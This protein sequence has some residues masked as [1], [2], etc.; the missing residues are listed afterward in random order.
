MLDRI[1]FYLKSITCPDLYL[2]RCSIGLY[3]THVFI[4]TICVFLGYLVKTCYKQQGLG[5]KGIQVEVSA[6]VFL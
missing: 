5:I 3:N 4:Y 1:V 6:P 2:V